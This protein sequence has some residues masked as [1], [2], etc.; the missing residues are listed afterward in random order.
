MAV[1][2]WVAVGEQL[3]LAIYGS[4][5]HVT[6]RKKKKK[7]AAVMKL[8]GSCTMGWITS[9]PRALISCWQVAQTCSEAN[10][11]TSATECTN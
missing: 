5:R 8:V 11:A 10:E 2:E 7:S 1:G 3:C 6:K 9:L 4:E